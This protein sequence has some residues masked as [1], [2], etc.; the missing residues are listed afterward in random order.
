MSKRV[1][2][3]YRRAMPHLFDSGNRQASVEIFHKLKPDY[4]ICRSCS[5]M[6]IIFDVQYIW[7]SLLYITYCK[8][9]FT[10][11]HLLIYLL[12]VASSDV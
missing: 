7:L 11:K 8:N 12:V 2:R 4:I 6:P 1:D 10:E 9:N 3:A 5:F